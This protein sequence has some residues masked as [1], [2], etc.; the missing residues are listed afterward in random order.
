MARHAGY[1]PRSFAP[2]LPRRDRHDAAAVADRAARRGGAAAARWC[3]DLRRSMRRARAGF[4][5]AV[6]LASTSRGWLCVARRRLPAERSG[7]R[8]GRSRRLM[9]GHARALD[10]P[11][12]DGRVPR[13]GG[14]AGG[15]ARAGDRAASC[16]PCCC[17]SS[18]RRSTRSAAAPSPGDLPFGED[19]GARAGSTSCA[20]GAAASSPT[21]GRASSSATRSCTRPDIP[22]FVRT[23]EAALVAAL[24]EEGIAARGR[25]DEGPEYTG[26]WVEDRKIASIGVHLSRGRERARLRDQRRQ[27]RRAVPPGH[28]LRAARR[29]HDL[30]RA[31]DRARGRLAVLR[32]SAPPTPSRRRTGCASGSSRRA[33]RT[34]VPRSIPS[35]REHR[36]APPA[37]HALAREPRRDGRH[38]GARHGHAAV[39]R[40][41]AAVVQGPAAGRRA[42]TASCRAMIRAEEPP[43]GLPGGR[44]PERRRLLGARH[45]DVHDPRRH[46]HAP[47]RLLQRQDRQADLERPA[48]A[49]ARRALGRE[50]GP[51]PRGHHLGRPRRPARLRRGRLGRR[52]PLD[53]HAGAVVQGRVPDARLPRR[54]DA[55][56]EGDRRAPRRLQPQRRGR[57]AAVPGRAPRLALGALAARA[58]Q[59]QGDGRRRGRRPSRA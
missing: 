14:A 5:T 21:T 32:A 53:P 51:A 54:G 1:S 55:A 26:V 20:R 38:E 57:A 44:L 56:R 30:G 49:A 29:A 34:P 59:R 19:T 36:P 40:P 31:R 23:M 52:D 17:C 25:D 58:R 37:R 48:R 24:A 50:D 45:R 42:S 3:T 15:A 12:R 6:G 16:P 43:H 47:L 9:V 18:T 33:A 22:A 27:R 35:L 4:G 8:L 10:L 2:A 39:P 7:R 13:G 46:V 28:R 11:P 41:Q